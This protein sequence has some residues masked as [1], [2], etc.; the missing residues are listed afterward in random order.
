M[1]EIFNLRRARK[2]KARSLKEKEAEANRAQHCVALRSRKRERALKEIA[3]KRLESLR[4]DKD[5]I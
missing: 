5:Q 3:A 2:N 4:L 1:A